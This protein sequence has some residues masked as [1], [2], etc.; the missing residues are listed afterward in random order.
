MS[1]RTDMNLT[2]SKTGQST[3]LVLLRLAA[4]AIDVRG[5][6]SP[7]EISQVPA[8]QKAL[9]AL[10]DV[11]RERYKEGHECHPDSDQSSL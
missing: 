4:I 5:M 10:D 3:E 11:F 2:A 9:N 7:Q 6:L 1:K 8:L